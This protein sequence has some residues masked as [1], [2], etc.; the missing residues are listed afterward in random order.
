MAPEPNQ[1]TGSANWTSR[2]VGGDCRAG[3]Q[4][5]Y[6]GR[7]GR[8]KGVAADEQRIEP[9]AD[10]SYEGRIDLAAGTRVEDLDFQP[11][12]ARRRFHISQRGLGINS[13]G[14]ID[15]RRYASGCGH[16]LVQ[17]FQPLCRQL[18]IEKV[19]ARRVATWPGEAGNKAEPDRVFADIKDDR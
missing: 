9:V 16:Q 8:K 7:P 10:K 19:D 15:E 4:F 17:E 6:W 11:K 13:K 18:I 12:G 1:S 2:F 5:D 3:R 14:R